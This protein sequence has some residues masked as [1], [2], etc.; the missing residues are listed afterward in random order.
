MNV[1]HGFE[2]VIERQLNYSKVVM[3]MCVGVHMYMYSTCVYV[4]NKMGLDIQSHR[5]KRDNQ[6][7]IKI[8]QMVT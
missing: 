7:M 2:T 4:C 3:R 8:K 5:T 6:I 1:D